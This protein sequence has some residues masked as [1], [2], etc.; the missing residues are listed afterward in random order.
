M[1]SPAVERGQLSPALPLWELAD[2]G[3][4]LEGLGDPNRLAILNLLAAQGELYGQQ[5]VEQ[6][7]VHQ[8]TISRN[9]TLL[10]RGRL[11][12]VRRAGNMKR[13]SLNRERIHEVCRLLS[14]ALG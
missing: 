14:G 5:I 8:S 6:V 12:H 1:T 2:L 7:G 3:Q 13:Y 11:V 4:A 10:E 9:L